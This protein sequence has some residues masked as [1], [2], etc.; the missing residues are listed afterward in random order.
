[1]QV[2]LGD[3]RLEVVSWALSSSCREHAQS[4]LLPR[5]VWEVGPGNSPCCGGRRISDR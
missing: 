5:D 2:Q 4:L 3:R 1:M